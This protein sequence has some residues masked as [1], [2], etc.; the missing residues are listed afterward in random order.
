L[1][2]SKRCLYPVKFKIH[3]IAFKFN[4]N[5][6]SN[7]LTILLNKFVLEYYT[8]KLFTFEKYTYQQNVL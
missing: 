8:Y 2:L 4:F 5:E 7:N 1:Y 3:E 6:A